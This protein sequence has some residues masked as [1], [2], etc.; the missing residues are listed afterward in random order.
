MLLCFD[1]CY[2]LQW[3][4]ITR[5]DC[6]VLFYLFV[7]LIVLTIHVHKKFKEVKRKQ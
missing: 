7:Y 4:F 5:C 3:P 6:D 1:V 2:Q